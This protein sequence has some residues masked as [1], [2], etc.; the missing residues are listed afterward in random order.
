MA[1][2]ASRISVGLVFGIVQRG[3]PTKLRSHA[4]YAVVPKFTEFH[5]RAALTC[6]RTRSVSSWRGMPT[7]S[8]KNKHSQN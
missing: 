5:Q 6:A 8:V 2:I 1:D 3:L 7:A 4:L